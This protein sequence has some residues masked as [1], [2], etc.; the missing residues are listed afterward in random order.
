MS[1]QIMTAATETAAIVPEIWSSKFY[2][3][4][5]D[6]LPFI[7]SVDKSYE[8]EIQNLGDIVNISTLPEFDQA[9]LLA[10]GARGNA[11]AVTITGQQ[12]TI[13]SR[14]YKDAIVTKKSQLQ[15]L[16]FMDELRDKM[17]FSIM[18]KMQAD[19]ISAIVPSASSPYHT[20]SYD[21]G[22]T[23]GLADI[24][25]AKELLDTQNV[26]EE[27]RVCVLGAAQWNDIF[28]I[29]GF[30]SRDFIPAG[31][32]LTSGSIPTPIA[33]FMPKMTNVV[34]STSYFF[35][36]SFLTMA[37]QDKLNIEVFNLGVDGVR[38]SRINADV[39]YGI[40]QLDD[41]RVVSIS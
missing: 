37:V 12:L 14:A 15:S 40:K 24:L 27:N 9:S 23:L 25:E 7:D 10:E 4:L 5:L 18:K 11:E 20:I 30:T 3:V 28:N 38:G 21:S 19:I 33:G 35:H 17:I 8:G 26:M 39:L 41:T 34:S 13:N 1:D 2:K 22:S 32:P 16:P 31:S 29:T 6:R 36:P